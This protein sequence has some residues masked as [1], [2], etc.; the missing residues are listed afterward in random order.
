M[1]VD[2]ILKEVHAMKDA[3]ARE[4]D[5]DLDTLFDRLKEAER[6]HPERLADKSTVTEK[7]AE[8]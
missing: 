2:P 7:P 4:V 5:Y 3:L 1:A 6:R 8:G